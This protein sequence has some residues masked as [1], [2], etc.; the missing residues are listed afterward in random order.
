[1][2]HIP[3]EVL[4]YLMGFLEKVHPQFGNLPP[5]PFAKKER[6]EGR[7]LCL[8]YSF[9]S[10]IPEKKL[11]DDIR[12][13]DKGH[14]YST[15]I[16]Y[17]KTSQMSLEE[18]YEMA[19]NLVD[20]LQ[21]IDIL[22]IPLHPK[23]PYSPS[24]IRTRA[25]PYLLF[26]IQR[27][28][29]L[30]EGQQKLLRTKY[31]SQFEDQEQRNLQSI[32]QQCARKDVFFPL[33]WWKE[34][35]LQSVRQGDSFPE[36]CPH[37]NLRMLNSNEIHN[38]FHQYGKIH[39]WIPFGAFKRIEEAQQ[40]VKKGRIIIATAH[41]GDKNGFVELLNGEEVVEGFFAE[42][43]IARFLWEYQIPDENVEQ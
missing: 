18:A 16:A 30:S 10:V 33:L 24:G 12:S 5:C 8:E 37:S 28:S 15:C 20:T 39:N 27:R 13:F 36:P 22:V 4:D 25:T 19:N 6:L 11:L 9:E 17:D 34:E 21:D 3:E 7:I 35:I 23:D 42:Y 14:T 31:Y 1:M 32:E 38:W 40:F 2:M 26:A 41:G 29:L 43:Y